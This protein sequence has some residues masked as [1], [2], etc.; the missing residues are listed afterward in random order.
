[1][2]FR[3]EIVSPEEDLFSGDAEFLRTETVEGEIGIL[4]GHAPILA[5]LVA[6]EVKVRSANGNESLFPIGG[7]FLSVK[8]NRAIILAEEVFNGDASA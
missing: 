8:E 2:A 4:T 7:G 5:Q 3:V 1:M 6:C